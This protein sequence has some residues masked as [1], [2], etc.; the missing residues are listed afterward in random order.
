METAVAYAIVFAIIFAYTLVVWLIVL[1]IYH[2]LIEPFDFGPL[3]TF[4]VKTLVIVAIVTTVVLL[5]PGGRYLALLIWWLGL[6][7]LF[8]RDLWESRMLVVLLW[9]VNFVVGLAL[10][11]WLLSL[12]QRQ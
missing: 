8:G 6:A 7:V 3:S 5:V 11:A 1:T 9:V 12:A 4:A 10:Q 2:N